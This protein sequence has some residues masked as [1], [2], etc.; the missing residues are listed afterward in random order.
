[1]HTLECVHENT[2]QAE[3]LQ[4]NTAYKA[5]QGCSPPT[6]KE[7]GQSSGPAITEKQVHGF[8]GKGLGARSGIRRLPLNV[9][10]NV[11]QHATYSKNPQSNKQIS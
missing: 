2:A 1:M 8:F 7:E 6:Q 3:T 10:L 5:N 11:S 9:P 4:E